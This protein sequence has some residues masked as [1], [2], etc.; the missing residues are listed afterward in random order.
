V[1]P[2]VEHLIL[3]E[4]LQGRYTS[5]KLLTVTAGSSTILH[6]GTRVGSR[7]HPT[8]PQQ[9]SWLAIPEICLPGEGMLCLG[10]GCVC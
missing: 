6:A 3:R 7:L 2:L 4:E 5:I 1:C 9:F 10:P 8:Q